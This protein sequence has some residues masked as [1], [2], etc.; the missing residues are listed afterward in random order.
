MRNQLVP[1]SAGKITYEI[2]N[3]VNVAEKL[4]KHGVK[5]NWEN[6]G[7][8]IVKGEII[9]DWMKEIVAKAAMDND[10]YGYA[11]TRGVLET[12]EFICNQTNRR[13]GAQITPD[14]IIFF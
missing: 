13:G 1:P 3:I 10:T 6:I 12:R 11:H 14:D 2:R 4:Q 5:I 8:P 9:P 7:D